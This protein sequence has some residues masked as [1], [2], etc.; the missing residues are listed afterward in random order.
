M[1][2]QSPLGLLVMA[3]GTPRSREEILPYYTHIRRGRAPSAEQLDDLTRRYE[4]IGGVSPLA[5]ITI[6]QA[7]GLA[8]LLNEDG[9]RP[10]QLYIG[11]K[12]ASPFIEDAVEAMHRDGIEECVGIVL[13]PHYSTM[14]IQSYQNSAK[15]KAE[16]LGGPKLR[17]IDNWHM[18]PL[19]LDLLA[20]R[21]TEGLRRFSQPDKVTTVFSAHS[22]PE[23]ILTVGDPY[24][25]QL[26]ESGEAVAKKLGLVHYDFAWQSAGQT[27]EPWLGPDIL[28]KLR[29]LAQNGIDNV[30]S[31]SQGFVA[32][33]LEVLY[34]IDI[35]AQAV[36]KELGLH[37]E[38]T[39]QLND[40]PAFLKALQ[41][42][43][44]ER[45]S[46]GEAQ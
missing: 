37:L 6:R 40:D 1:S 34:D 42:V 3:Y 13:A 8:R 12:H 7:E 39:R 15:A 46:R 21:V 16:Q 22:L 44:R 4:S 14:S 20:D 45:E 25:A 23:R 24:P 33:H 28:D 30:L 5:E 26:R 9:G 36:A 10:V 41:S 27:G 18:N 32:D 29:E 35:E 43:V 38:R 11:L 2:S 17:L 31:C 19:F